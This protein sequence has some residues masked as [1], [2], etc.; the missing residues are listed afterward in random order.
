V[1]LL[2]V[3]LAKA[4]LPPVTC[5]AGAPIGNVDLRIISP[6]NPEAL[7]LRTINRLNEG[8]IIR[9]APILRSGE[10]RS[11]EVSL[12]LAPAVPESKGENVIVLDPKPAAKPAEWKVSRKISVAIFV[13]GPDGLNRGKVKTFLS[14]DDDL[15]S[16]LADYAE[17]TTQTE[18]LIQALSSTDGSPA[19]AN[20]ALQGFA[21]QYGLGGRIDKTLPADQQAMALFRTVNPAMEGADPLASVSSQ[22]V[23]ETA[24]IATSI[25]GLFFG[26]P[27]GLAAGGTAMLIDL[28]MLA[29]P[30]TDFRSSIEE[31]LPSDGMGLCGKRGAPAPHTKIAYLWASR[32]PN[33]G[34]PTFTIGNANSIPA[35]Q[36]S[37]LPVEVSDNDWK[38][39]DR[40][41]NW[42]IVNDSGKRLPVVVSR[43]ATGKN[44]E[45]DLSR[46][47]VAPGEYRLSA[48]WDWDRFAINGSLHVQRLSDFGAAHVDLMSQDHLI[49]GKGKTRVTLIGSDFE[50]VTAVQ[51]ERANDEFAKPAPVPFVLPEGLRRGPQQHLD[52]LVDTKD[53]EPGKYQFFLAQV[54]DRTHSIPFQLL[55]DPPSITNLPVIISRGEHTRVV[56]LKGENLDLLA[57]LETPEGPVQ[58]GPALPKQTERTATI[59]V[60]NDLKPGSA[61]DIDAFISGHTEPIKFT[62]AIHVVGPHPAITEA[63]VS[64]PTDM[65]I[66]LQ[67]GELPAGVFVSSLLQVENL[68]TSSGIRLSCE[69]Q[70]RNVVALH[71]GEHTSTANLQQLGPDQV[72]L[73]FDTNG[74]PAGCTIQ[75][76]VDNGPDGISDPCRLGRLIRMPHIDTFQITNNDTDTGTYVGELDGTDL[77]NIEK[78]G[79]YANA[80]SDVP[81]LPSP[82]PGRGMEQSLRIK[83]PGPSPVPHAPLYIWLR[84]DNAGRLT[85]VHDQ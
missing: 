5:P 70:E 31:K 72:F 59:Q 58:L 50:F 2:P 79:W 21:S 51:L 63:K 60:K 77:Q 74:W 4:A 49:A 19:S 40:V 11:G 23:G 85:N 39:F 45:V 62:N 71:M 15:V 75:A 55:P 26:S 44:L 52:L 25:A 28:K 76:Q 53:L 61:F 54:D 67:P 73:S 78:V 80:G 38:Y 3:A 56:T 34:A 1:A 13:Y 69:G 33:A 22:R 35:H 6:G 36:I 57:K 8:D 81:D 66:A 29:F 7:P 83:I 42:S 32:I 65:A 82:I 46:T 37:P 20:A 24:S 84:G 17:K 47:N 41:R 18:A 30:K 10:K 16:Q 14:K 12:V 68:E 9:Y 48:N 43:A 27:V 64:P